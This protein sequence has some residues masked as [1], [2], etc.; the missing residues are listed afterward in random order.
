MDQLLAALVG[1]LASGSVYGLIGLGL[2]IIFRSTDVIN[3]ASASIAVLG[4][5]LGL[6]VISWGAP[7]LIGVVVVVA[8]AAVVGA[9]ARE[10][11]LRPLGEGQLFAAL[12]TTMGL[13]LILDHL[14]AQ[15]WGTGPRTFPSL[16]TGYVGVAGY[17]LQY[18]D[19]LTMAMALVAVVLV[20]YLFTRTSLGV[21]MRAVA[22]SAS[23]AKVLGID[24][25]AI[26]RRAW[27]LGSAL[28]ALGTVLLLP[29]TG[30]APA[31]LAGALFRAF[32][33]IF[34]GGLNS[35]VGAVVGGIT[36][37]ILDNLAAAYLSADFRDTIVFSV[38]VAVLLLR[39]QGIFGKPVFERV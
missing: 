26:A 36:I 17:R 8:G 9:A 16:V 32:A 14:V 22:D 4:A 29:R 1:G 30:L 20:A 5:Y 37:G 3:F 39:P 15:V 35:M 12:V 28:A 21:A 38:A 31:I 19:L 10:I 7:L 18:Q 13:S 24:P 2:V 6:E 27:L 23:T 11:T 33:G 34:L 25:Q